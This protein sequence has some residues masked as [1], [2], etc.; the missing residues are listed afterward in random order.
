MLLVSWSVLER[1]SAMVDEK[2]RIVCEITVQGNRIEVSAHS[3]GVKG[4]APEPI[5]P[6]NKTFKKDGN[7]G[8]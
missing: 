8:R 3:N 1:R 5:A 4:A 2:S 7:E 6:A